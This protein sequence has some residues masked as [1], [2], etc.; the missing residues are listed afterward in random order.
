MEG[1][2]KIIIKK[3][4]VMGTGQCTSSSTILWQIG[5]LCTGVAQLKSRVQEVNGYGSLQV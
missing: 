2:I 1:W 5:E 3:K 4:G